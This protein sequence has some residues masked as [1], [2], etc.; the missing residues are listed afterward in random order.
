MKLLTKGMCIIGNG[1]AAVEAIKA[2]RENNY[3]GDINLISDSMWPSY[4]PMLTTYYVSG[5]IEFGD[6]FPFGYNMDFYKENNVKL[7]LGSPV[8][9]LD[10]DKK[11]VI[12]ENGLKFEF[13]KCLIATG[14]SPFM[15]PIKG[16]NLKN[17]FA[18]RTVEDALKLKDALKKSPKKAVVVGAS[19]VGIK[20][21]ELLKDAGLK[22]T[23]ADQAPCMFPLAAHE[24][25]AHLIQQVLIDKGIDLKFGAAITGIE[26]IEKGLSVSFGEDVVE[27]DLVV[28][29]IGVRPNLKFVNRNQITVDRGIVVDDSM[30]TNNEDIYAAGD[31][32]QGTNILTGEKQIIGLWTNARYQGRTA[33]RNMAGVKDTF[34]GN[35]PHNITHFMD[36]IF[37]GLGDL[38]HG[39]RHE[40]RQT[41]DSYVHLVW[42]QEKLV[43]VNMLGDSCSNIGIIKNALE[44]RLISDSFLDSTCLCSNNLRD[45]LLINYFNKSK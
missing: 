42:N 3:A 33:G 22:V 26:E 28:I 11:T 35:I 43:G 15:P 31:V 45:N 37:T 12:T 25:C 30:R 1:S 4:N 2:L 34:K 6:M 23:L 9:E 41:K 16:I 29:C 19:M 39:D 36:M 44:K 7:H 21:V 20:V 10:A 13:D 38:Q 14:A 18:M 27:A 32:S 5:K 24:E 17:V 40:T 8:V